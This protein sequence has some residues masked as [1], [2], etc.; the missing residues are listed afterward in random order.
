MV[1]TVIFKVA[2]NVFSHLHAQRFTV[3]AD[4]VAPS[5]FPPG[6]LKGMLDSR[7]A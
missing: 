7:N 1:R 6:L 4:L 5:P 3:A 2:D